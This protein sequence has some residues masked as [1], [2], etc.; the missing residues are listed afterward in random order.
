MNEKLLLGRAGGVAGPRAA[1]RAGA[2]A[3]VAGGVAA[4]PPRAPLISP[5]PGLPP[6]RPPDK[7]RNPST[8]S[9]KNSVR[10]RRLEVAPPCECPT[11]QNALILMFF[12]FAC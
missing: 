9:L 3:D 8:L 5:R 2:V 7:L 10:I 11:S 6:M 12:S 1:P 4:R